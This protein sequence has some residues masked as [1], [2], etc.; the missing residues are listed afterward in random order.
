MTVTQDPLREK[1]ALGGLHPF[2]VSTPPDVSA[3]SQEVESQKKWRG[4]KKERVFPSSKYRS[5]SRNETHFWLGR[6][7]LPKGHQPV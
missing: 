6:K 7:G 4:E 1:D 2:V 5:C 3:Q